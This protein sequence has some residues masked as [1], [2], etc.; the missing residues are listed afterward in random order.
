MSNPPLET[1]ENL[2]VTTYEELFADA[3]GRAPG[4]EVRIS[5]RNLIG[6]WDARRRGSWVIERIQNALDDHG[7]ATVPSF[8]N[9]WIDNIIV[10]F[11]LQRALLQPGSAETADIQVEEVGPTAQVVSNTALRFADLP[12]ADGGVTRIRRDTSVCEAQSL[13]I[14]SDFSQMPV[15]N[16]RDLQG[17][18]SWESISRA[19]M[20][21]SDATLRDA[22]VPATVVSLD[23][24]VLPHVADIIRRG[25][26]FV[27]QRDR[28][29]NGIVTTTDLS[30]AFER[31]A[32]PFLLVGDVE[33]RLRRIIHAT[34]SLA[35]LQAVHGPNDTGRSIE[36]V[37]HMTTG[38]YVRLLDNPERWAKLG[39]EVDRRVFVRSLHAYRELRNE[40][41]HF[42]PDPLEESKVALV[43]NLLA[44]LRTAAPDNA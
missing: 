11:P 24:E 25:F 44:W 35:D 22:I 4:N 9:G 31:L 39:W 1:E 42:S 32:G 15:V 3:A 23:D 10:L 20:H 5:I 6:Y 19:R 27:R 41:M 34:F 7:L 12:T 26:V 14:Q 38:E 29:I 36:S 16:G 37:E 8:E 21:K 28:T 33:R 18:V 40:V 17:A 2:E 13:M 30:A 43:R